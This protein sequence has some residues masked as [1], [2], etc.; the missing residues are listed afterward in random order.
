[1]IGTSCNFVGLYGVV[2]GVPIYI[3]HEQSRNAPSADSFELWLLQVL[4]ENI[5]SRE[6]GIIRAESI[7]HMP[8]RMI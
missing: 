6:A 2:G 8:I 3:C 1:M 5:R 7:G 4:M